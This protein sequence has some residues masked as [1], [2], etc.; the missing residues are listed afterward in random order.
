MPLGRYV[1][2]SRKFVKSLQNVA[3]VDTIHE[4]LDFAHA[5]RL[6][7]VQVGGTQRSISSVVQV[8]HHVE[9][10]PRRNG[11]GL[12]ELQNRGLLGAAICHGGSSAIEAEDAAARG[13]VPARRL[14]LRLVADGQRDVH[15]VGSQLVHG[16]GGSTREPEPHAQGQH[17][18][19]VVRGEGRGDGHVRPVSQAQVRA[20]EQTSLLLHGGGGRSVGVSANQG[21][22]IHMLR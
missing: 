12:G 15:L 16:Q 4:H 22:P 10:L 1:V 9:V 11:D 7:C 21:I 2:I 6:T 3:S 18:V 8:A 19:R 5:D 14:E 13:E 20:V 17:D